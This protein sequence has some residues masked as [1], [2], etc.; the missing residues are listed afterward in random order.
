MHTTNAQH[1]V[2]G[3]PAV[4][5]WNERY[6]AARPDKCRLCGQSDDG[7][8]TIVSNGICRDT[9]ECAETQQGISDGTLTV[10]QPVKKPRKQPIVDRKGTALCTNPDCL[11]A[12]KRYPVTSLSWDKSPMGNPV[13]REHW[14]PG[15]TDYNSWR[16]EYKRR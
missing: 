14:R 15:T 1:V 5:N 7:T 10:Q 3:I 16:G 13:C 9:Q 2:G 8:R 6:A 4:T 12:G 11:E